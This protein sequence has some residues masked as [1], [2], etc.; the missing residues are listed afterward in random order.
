M[1]TVS[2]YPRTRTRRRPRPREGAP[3][4]ESRGVRFKAPRWNCAP[5]DEFEDENHP[6]SLARYWRA[7]PA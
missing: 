5:S 4:L 2:S 1:I 6:A 7:I 3:E